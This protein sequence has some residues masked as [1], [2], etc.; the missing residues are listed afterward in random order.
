MLTTKTLKM[1]VTTNPRPA[2]QQLDIPKS[3][4]LDMLTNT[5]GRLTTNKNLDMLNNK[6]TRHAKTKHKTQQTEKKTKK[7]AKMNAL[8]MLK[9]HTLD[10]LKQTL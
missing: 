7:H 8:D 4:T 3:N 1:L 9:I 5:L 6:K 10:M 2:K